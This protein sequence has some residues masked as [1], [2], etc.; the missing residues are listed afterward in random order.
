MIRL[1]C[2]LQTSMSMKIHYLLEPGQSS[3]ITLANY[4]NSKTS[5][6]RRRL[7]NPNRPDAHPA[8][9]FHSPRLRRLLFAHTFSIYVSFGCSYAV[10]RA[11]RF[12]EASS[13]NIQNLGDRPTAAK[14]CILIKST[15]T[16]TAHRP[17]EDK[18]NAINPL[19][20]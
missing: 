5:R 12:C 18:I 2:G 1:K 16:N 6:P 19:Q 3:I 14:L 10:H 4:A 11:P 8:P 17:P 20:I 15:S 13:K 9:R 7:F